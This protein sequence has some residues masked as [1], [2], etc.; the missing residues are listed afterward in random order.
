MVAAARFVRRLFARRWIPAL[1]LLCGSMAH[2]DGLVPIRPTGRDLSLKWKSGTYAYRWFPLSGTPHTAS[3]AERDAMEWTLFART[4]DVMR[5]ASDLCPAAATYACTQVN[6]VTTRVGVGSQYEGAL[7]KPG[8]KVWQIG[9]NGRH[10]SVE[11]S[12]LRRFRYCLRSTRV[13][14]ACAE[15][16]GA[17]AAM[18]D[19]RDLLD[20]NETCAGDA[21]FTFGPIPSEV[22]G[23]RED[24]APVNTRRLLPP[25]TPAQQEL[26]HQTHAAHAAVS[27]WRCGEGPSPAPG[28]V[29]AAH[30]AYEA[31][32]RTETEQHFFAMKPFSGYVDPRWTQDQVCQWARIQDVFHR[33]WM[34]AQMAGDWA[35]ARQAD[36]DHLFAHLCMND[37]TP[38][39]RVLF[40]CGNRQRIDSCGK[41]S[42]ADALSV[43][44]ARL[45][46]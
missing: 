31:S 6:L 24:M 15:R 25:R 10:Y 38:E 36:T 2:A 28:I 5:A 12:A 33:R 1:V 32:A 43:V 4:L 14:A 16:F 44:S 13:R 42:C 7:Q 23:A 3:Q 19:L 26:L 22:D 46:L 34:Q 21:A 29:P 45:G 20:L 37:A 18:V 9:A 41:L 40:S 11:R 30:L 17:S 8:G 35:A 39:L 27:S